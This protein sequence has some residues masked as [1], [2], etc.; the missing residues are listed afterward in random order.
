QEAMKDP[1]KA[2]ELKKKFDEAMR[3]ARGKDSD[4]TGKAG[5]DPT[6]PL[7]PAMAD[8]PRNRAKSAELQLEELKKALDNPEIRK[9]AG[10]SSPEE[11]ERFLEGYERMVKEL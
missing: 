7:K 6:A 8:D 2:E 5:G 3:Q 1:Q 9:Q 11:A 4:P 10:F